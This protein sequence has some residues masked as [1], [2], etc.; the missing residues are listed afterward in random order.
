MRRNS[1]GLRKKV[2]VFKLLCNKKISI[3]LN[4]IA[5]EQS[6][7]N[8][9]ISSSHHTSSSHYERTCIKTYYSNLDLSNLNCST[10][11]TRQQQPYPIGGNNNYYDLQRG[12][13]YDFIDQDDYQPSRNTY[14]DYRNFHENSNA[15][16]FKQ[17]Q[18][19]PLA[20]NK[21][22]S[23]FRSPSLPAIRHRE[24][25][26]KNRRQDEITTSGY[27]SDSLKNSHSPDIWY[28]EEH[29]INNNNNS[30]QQMHQHQQNVVARSNETRKFTATD[31]SSGLIDRIP[32]SGNL[33]DYGQNLSHVR[34]PPNDLEQAGIPIGNES[35]MM[36]DNG[37]Q[38]QRYVYKCVE[39]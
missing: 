13:S 39:G 23:R 8:E 22:Q 20:T 31:N 38:M 36:V 19:M 37:Y 34:H 17:Q 9:M 12:N 26:V 24:Y 10:N 6:R 18:Q 25:G 21:Q 27:V 4:H 32:N 7:M 28:N 35:G 11:M 33:R 1:N 30:S 15:P 2:S 14:I 29:N 5:E 3:I 16:P